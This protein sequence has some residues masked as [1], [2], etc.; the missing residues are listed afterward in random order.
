VPGS[1]TD[2]VETL[3]ALLTSGTWQMSAAERLAVEGIVAAVRPRLAIEIGTAE[4][5]SLQRIAAHSDEVHAFDLVEPQIDVDAMPGVTMHVGDSHA[6]LPRVLAELAD[7]GRTVDF[8]L[9]DGDHSAEGARQDVED[10]L[11]SPA[12][13]QTVILCHDASNPDVRRGLD[14]VAY[15]DFD[16][17][18]FVDMDFVQGVLFAEPVVDHTMWGG[19][20]I[21][22]TAPAGVPRAARDP[23]LIHGFEKTVLAARALDASR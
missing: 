10:L 2:S 3:L 21:I 9:V 1:R 15:G 4:G 22:V 12:T 7:A 20:G 23:R 11:R 19:L 5:G 18:A 14:A 8:A 6:N 16:K 17:V 13:E